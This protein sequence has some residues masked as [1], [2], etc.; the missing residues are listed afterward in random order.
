MNATA[1][2][3]EPS[4]TEKSVFSRYQKIGVF[5]GTKKSLHFP[6]PENVLIIGYRNNPYRHPASVVVNT[7]GDGRSISS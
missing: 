4:G 7:D 3:F 2:S 1:V 5:S 6:V